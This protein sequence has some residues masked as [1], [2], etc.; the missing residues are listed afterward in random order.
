MDEFHLDDMSE[1]PKRLPCPQP[2][3]TFLGKTKNSLRDHQKV[4]EQHFECAFP[5][6][7]KQFRN[8][9]CLL[10]HQKMHC[11]NREFA[12]D[13]CPQRFARKNWLAR[14]IKLVHA[15]GKQFHCSH[16]DFSCRYKLQMTKHVNKLHGETRVSGGPGCNYRSHTRDGFAQYSKRLRDDGGSRLKCEHCAYRFTRKTALEKH[17][18]KLHANQCQESSGLLVS[19]DCKTPA[20]PGGLCDTSRM[21][22]EGELDLFRHSLYCKIAVVVLPRIT[23]QF[24]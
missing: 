3:C 2:G 8:E 19:E 13:Q 23:V 12:C 22:F 15:E 20:R 10:R 16:C 14:H 1:T 4:H 7:Q 5:M 17:C 11:P 24:P 18:S 9:V 6:G 21:V